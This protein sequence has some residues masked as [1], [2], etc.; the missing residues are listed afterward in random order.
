MRLRRIVWS[1]QNRLVPTAAVAVTVKGAGMHE[2]VSRSTRRIPVLA[3]GLVLLLLAPAQAR[4]AN[5]IT[6]RAHE[7]NG[8]GTMG[9]LL[10]QF[11]YIVNEDN[12][13]DPLDPDPLRRPSM[14][15]TES[16]SPLVAR[17]DQD[18]PPVSLPDGRYL[19][20]V[21][22]PD[23]KLWGRHI[24]LPHDAGTIDV[25]L[26]SERLP[27]ATI[28]VF[29]FGDNHF[30]NS[31]PDEGE[32]GLAGFHVTL[33]EQT[34]T[35]VS[36]DYYNNA[37]CG[38]DCVTDANGEVTIRNLSPAT[39]TAFVTPPDESDW[40]QTST[41]LG[42]F[43]AT[44][45]AEEGGDGTNGP[46]GLPA[47]QLFLPPDQRTGLTFG[48]VRPKDFTPAGSGSIS[49]V[50]RNWVGYPPFDTLVV[51][52]PVQNPIVA[53]SDSATDEQVFTGRGDSDGNF[54]IPDVRPSTYIMA[55]W[56]EQLTYIIRL[57]T[58]TVA[59]GEQVDLGD[60]GVARWF[61]WLSGY[62]YL[63]D[64]K[65]ED[66]TV[67]DGGAGNGLR[68]CADRS[69]PATCERGIPNTDVDQRWR[70]GSIKGVTYTGADGRYEY[71]EA[72]GGN[73]G[74]F[75]IGEVGFA[76]F[77]T[78][79]ASLHD[80]IHY[81]TV[82]RVPQ[83]QGGGLLTNQYTIEGHR[84]EVDWGKET[85]PQGTPGQIVG[86]TYWGTTRNEFDARLQAHEDYEPGVADVTVRLEGLGPDNLPGT[87]DDPVLND[88]VSD[89]WQGPTDCDLTDVFGNPV[90]GLNPFIAPH[91]IE[92][93][94]LDTSVLPIAGT[95][96]ELPP[97]T[98]ELLQA[99]RPYVRA[100]TEGNDN[101]PALR[102]ITIDGD[103]LGTTPGSVTLADP[104]GILQSRT[105]T[106]LASAAQLANLNTGGI[107][108][109][110]ARRIVLQ[111]PAPQLL[112]LPGQKQLSIR[113]AGAAGVESTNGLTLHV[114]GTVG[115]NAYNPQIV[116][117][118]APTTNPH[119]LQNAI[120][121]ANLIA[122][123]AGGTPPLVVLAPGIYSENVVISKPLKLQGLG[124][125]GIV[126]SNEPPNRVPDDARFNIPGTSLDGRFFADDRTAWRSTV[127]A[128]GTLAGVDA[129]H[130]VLEGADITV[131][132]KSQTA[133][134]IGSGTTAVFDAARIDGLGI[135]GGRG[136][137]AGGVQLQAYAKNLRISNDV[138]QSDG[139]TFAGAIGI[140]QPY[141][142]S[143][144]TGVTIAYDRVIGSGG[145]AR[146]GGI[147]IFTGSNNYEVANSI[148][149]SN[150]SVEYGG[151]LSHWGRSTGGSIHDNRI[152][153]N[154]SF[155]SAGG[156]LISQEV[157]SP[158]ATA[159]RGSVT[160]PAT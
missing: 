49:G 17:G 153:Y 91:C 30:V 85:Y 106:G 62:V 45:G 22:S 111:V 68:D 26:R 95:G 24:T 130:P 99:S 89:K 154:E 138:L 18:S 118:A 112:F 117:A 67:L 76:R 152:Y 7:L 135:T 29:V 140:G 54:S 34:G 59:D 101:T 96:C 86:V 8:N 160:A 74:K 16:N 94:A 32:A 110:T 47:Q 70:D 116:T 147:G 119:A 65:A 57:L 46:E 14:A 4:A 6:V 151:G 11:T 39:Y 120:N 48:F 60:V 72:E 104:R 1:A 150:Y 55:I 31:Q 37:L 145:L 40:I 121:A 77:A 148:L 143:Q 23:H 97:N 125:G 149:C 15:P 113:T 124:P 66:G 73:V 84:S 155:D 134:N 88:Y 33:S 159:T 158:T 61:G 50:A 90:S 63:D 13:R 44:V 38:G 142:D 87:P 2:L 109:W 102:R 133:Y 105:F 19:I 129:S 80:E 56:D 81:D 100:A 144:N 58:V 64:G 122:V 75:F 71:P 78:N 69:D 131:V 35:E 115:G 52:E 53:L 141:A 156:I 107:V 42:G 136:D 12:A 114:L 83:A 127:N 10:P 98:P 139:G 36:V 5:A 123:P 43:G 41:F 137:G 132:A 108:S 157:P 21:R 3:F 25:A 79:G 146:A 82:A 51:N 27:L 128:L 103:F 92:V 126:G 9:A 93:P 28:K 20:S